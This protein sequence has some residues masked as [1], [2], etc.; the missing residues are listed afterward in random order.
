MEI[1]NTENKLTITVA[2]LAEYLGIGRNSA[3]TLVNSKDFPKIQIGRKIIIPIKSLEK[4]I[5]RK[6]ETF[7]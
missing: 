4:W 7:N 3:Y 6:S 1:I 2:E 5:E